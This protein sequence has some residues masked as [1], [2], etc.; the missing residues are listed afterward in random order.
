MPKVIF[1]D[2]V[3]TLFNVRSSV[4]EAYNKIASRFGVQVSPEV[5]N[6]AF[7]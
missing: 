3:G 4:G 2:A 5:L 7:I 6:R 1:L